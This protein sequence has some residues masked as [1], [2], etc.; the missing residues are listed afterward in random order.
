MARTFAA[1]SSELIRLGIGNLGA[2]NRQ[3]DWTF[4]FIVRR[5]ATNAYH[6]V[7]GVNN[8]TTGAGAELIG[9]E[10]DNFNRL[11]VAVT[12]ADVCRTSSTFTS[13]TS[14]ILGFATIPADVTFTTSARFHWVDLSNWAGGWTHQAATNPLTTRTSATAGT[15][16]VRIGDFENNDFY[17]GDI[18]R[19]AVWNKTFSDNQ[20]ESMGV[21]LPAWL[22]QGPNVLAELRQSAVADPVRDLTGHGS[23]EA[24]RTGTTIASRSAPFV[25][26]GPG[27]KL[28]I[29]TVGSGTT[30]TKTGIGISA[31][32]SLGG[33]ALTDVNTGAAVSDRTAS[34]PD[35]W[36]P[37]ETGAGISALTGSG[38]DVVTYNRTGIGISAREASGARVSS[39]TYSKSGL[40][41]VG[42]IAIPK[43]GI[44]ITDLT[45]SGHRNSVFVESGIGISTRTGSGASV[46]VPPGSQTTYSKTGRGILGA[47]PTIK[48]GSAITTYT[49]SGT[50]TTA[51]AASG[52][53]Y[54]KT[55]IGIMGKLP[56]VKTGIGISD[57]TAS[58][59]K[60]YIPYT[61]G[62]FVKS[63]G[64][65]GGTGTPTWGLLTLSHPGGWVASGSK[66]VTVSFVFVK[67]GTGITDRVA[68]G[69][70][71]F[72]SGGASTFFKSGM[73][74]TRF[75]SSGPSALGKV[76][77][78]TGSG[79]TPYSASGADLYIPARPPIIKSGGGAGGSGTPMWGLLSLAHAVGWSASGSKSIGHVYFK[80][81]AAITSMVVLGGRNSISAK[82]GSGVTPYVASGSSTVIVSPGN[83]TF[84]KSGT[85]LTDYSVF[86]P[87]SIART[88]TGGALTTAT[89]SGS[90]QVAFAET[91]AVDHPYVA[92]GQ[93][94]S[95]A[96][97]TGMVKFDMT[98]GGKIT[99]D[100]V[101]AGTA[102]VDYDAKGKR[103]ARIRP[104]QHTIKGYIGKRVVRT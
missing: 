39:F 46:Y 29:P 93:D 49:A 36:V 10:F 2:I 3:S 18:Q 85:A 48:T 81:G 19:V 95:L 43:T 88:R 56:I 77:F 30:Y 103:A 53:T 8:A 102:I 55:G 38:A 23:D 6:A 12:G 71:T 72:I 98:G 75:V 68:R 99:K 7:V 86:G 54:T 100:F 79:I 31:L 34:G 40:G 69:S 25:R 15:G 87:R 20:I 63:G 51:P 42:A 44:A 61:P 5:G 65:A 37:A 52:S 1:G 96:V 28:F 21:S 26:Y 33:D 104:T 11:I 74:V 47:I 50:E 32:A 24:S 14:W 78:K 80:T 94:I 27:A 4:G 22:A 91:G 82:S 89:G 13:T 17:S 58:G 84:N 62:L 9:I 35:S 73:G 16:S 45:G 90:D 101:K 64:G 60:V 41:V 92:S 67:S 57:R 83:T 59:A 97:R 76:Y 70:K 66:V